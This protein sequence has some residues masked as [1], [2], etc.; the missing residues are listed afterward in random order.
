MP[1]KGPRAL[2]IW[3]KRITS[4]YQNVNITNMSSSWRDGLGF[5][6]LIHYHCPHLINY[7]ALH[8]EQIF[9]NN[10]LAFQVA[11]DFLGIPSLL[12]PKDMVDS[13][14]VDKLSILTYIAQYYIAMHKPKELQHRLSSRKLSQSF[15]AP[16][17]DSDCHIEKDTNVADQKFVV[18]GSEDVPSNNL[19]DS[20]KTEEFSRRPSNGV[21][22]KDIN[23]ALKV[24]GTKPAYPENCNV[25]AL[26]TDNAA[27][28]PVTNS[29]IYGL[30]AL[31]QDMFDLDLKIL[32]IKIANLDVKRMDLEKKIRE[33]R[34]VKTYDS[35]VEINDEIIEEE[36]FVQLFDLVDEKNDLIRKQTEMMFSKKEV[37]LR[38]QQD[39][40]EK[41]VRDLMEKPAWTKTESDELEEARLVNKIV[42]IVRERNEIV[43]HLELD[44]IREVEQVDACQDVKTKTKLL[45]SKNE[46]DK[47]AKT[48][49]RNKMFS[50]ISR[51]IE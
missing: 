1:L 10:S 42:D 12:D 41:Q 45:G 13:H 46:K 19:V 6:A 33:S 48:P 35:N 31:D 29:C 8:S 22:T 36:L 28:S 16:K 24:K 15:A 34:I 23:Q 20:H 3:C 39:K 5:C 25:T 18:N 9:E 51:K 50:W 4:G 21:G 43:T 17:N 14:V 37:Q 30:K 49:V 7:D 38:D 2:E 32:D 44:R 47:L 11:E 26:K 27:N 40:C